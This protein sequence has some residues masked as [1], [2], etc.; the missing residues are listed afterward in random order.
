MK[1]VELRVDEVIFRQDLYP[2]QEHDPVLVQ[3]Y[4]RNLGL[5]PA[6]EVNQH[7]WLIDGKHRWLGHQT[8]KAETIQA[9]VTPTATEAE[10][11]AL[12]CRR[13]AQHGRQLSDADK[14]QMAIR[15]YNGGEGI[16]KQKEIAD[17]LSVTEEAVSRYLSDINKQLEEQRRKVIF[18]MWLAC[19]T[20]DEI[21]AAVGGDFT[22]Q[23]VN[24]RKV[25]LQKLDEHQEVVKLAAR[26]QPTGAKKETP[27]EVPLYNVWTFAKKSNEVEHFGN[28]E[29]RILNNLLYLYTEPFQIVVDPFAGGGATIDVCKRRLR[30]YWV[31]DRKPIPARAGA[32]RTLDVVQEM[33][34]LKGRWDDVALVYLDPP[35]WKQAEHQY[36]EDAEDLANMPLDQFTEALA[37]VILRFA[38]RMKQG[39]IALLMQPTQ[40]RAPEKAFTDH[41]A[42]LLLAVRKKKKLRLCNRVQVPYST[43]Q[44]N[45]QQVEWAKGNKE[46]LVI[47]RELLLWR[48]NGEHADS[49]QGAD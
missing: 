8:A 14:K 46:L 27:F 29:Q 10:F 32:I 41:V 9:F 25:V 18:D 47:S 48:V 16:K 40:W 12:A 30:R 13:N 24:K 33:P 28:S 36:S 44:C 39:M 5:L 38:D 35:Y 7:H 1:T 11:I 26:F 23:A 17:I 6:I 3:Q 49:R 2:R 15:L 42:D 22:Q 45:A 43:E 19:H 20:D 31:S 21:A 4:S 34:A 37:G